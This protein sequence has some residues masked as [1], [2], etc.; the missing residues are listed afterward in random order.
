MCG[1]IT[2]RQYRELAANKQT[3]YRILGEYTNDQNQTA[4]IVAD[5][6]GDVS[7]I[8]SEDGREYS[9]FW[10][11]ASETRK[12][13]EFA[14]KAMAERGFKLVV[15]TNLPEQSTEVRVQGKT[16]AEWE[17]EGR[18]NEDR[19]DH[20]HPTQPTDR[21]PTPDENAAWGNSLTDEETRAT[22]YSLADI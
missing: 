5:P 4:L 15:Q 22:M 12:Q 2:Q 1:I 20:I 16:L 6:Y 11:K 21:P 3:G 8:Y 14:E 19:K 18:L 10:G 13:Q 9:I 17:E 7:N